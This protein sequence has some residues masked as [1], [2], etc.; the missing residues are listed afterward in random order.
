MI[1]VKRDVEGVI[2]TTLDG[3]PAIGLCLAEDK[4]GSGNAPWELGH[5]LA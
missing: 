1:I 4:P 5:L 2:N 3:Q